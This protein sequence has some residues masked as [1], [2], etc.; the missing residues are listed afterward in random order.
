MSN[1]STASFAKAKRL[2]VS[3]D[4][5][6]LFA[7]LRFN[8]GEMLQT[9]VCVALAEIFAYNKPI[10]FMRCRIL[11]LFGL[12]GLSAR[13]GILGQRCH[14]TAELGEDIA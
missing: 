7:C 5:G 12:I 10:W 14:H 13:I 4:A 2:L 6:S 9:P 11:L 8:C 1:P 3:F